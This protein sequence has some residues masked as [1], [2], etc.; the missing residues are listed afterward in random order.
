ML[1]FSHHFI[2]TAKKNLMKPKSFS[3][4]KPWTMIRCFDQFCFRTLNSSLEGAMKLEAEICVEIL[5]LGY[6]FSFFFCRSLNLQFKPWSIILYRLY[7]RGVVD[8]CCKQSGLF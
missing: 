4:Q 5:L 7:K 6:P 2:R 3:G 1:Y 8:V